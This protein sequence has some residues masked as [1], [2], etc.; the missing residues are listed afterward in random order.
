MLIR[1]VPE[2]V[3]DVWDS[4]KPLLA[5]SLVPTVVPDNAAM[6][7]VLEEILQERL[8][9]WVAEGK[10]VMTTMIISEIVTRQKNLLLY[11]LNIVNHLTPKE[12]RG[13]AES[14]RLYAES[15]GCQNI[16][17][18]ANNEKLAKSAEYAGFKTT[19]TVGIKEV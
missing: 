8:V 13:Y 6:Y 10:L 19:W 2:Q 11:S 9:V 5:E 15:V 16:V 4:L 7:R 18:Y 3:N 17:F 14:L 1:L 12:F